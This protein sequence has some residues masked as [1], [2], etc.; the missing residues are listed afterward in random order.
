MSSSS[1]LSYVL[2]FK[3][4]APQPS[5][6]GRHQHRQPKRARDASPPREAWT[7]PPSRLPGHNSAGRGVAPTEVIF[8]SSP[9]VVVLQPGEENKPYALKN[10]P[11]QLIDQIGNYISWC[12]ADINTERSRRYIKA[13]QTTSL[14]KTE[15]L[16]MAFAGVVFAYYDLPRESIN[17]SIYSNPTYVARFVGYLQVGEQLK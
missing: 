11:R 16:V 12:K 9:P 5:N 3:Q 6:G 13:V 2:C 14:A 7:T 1:S 4:V 8:P 15:S 10:P 17:L